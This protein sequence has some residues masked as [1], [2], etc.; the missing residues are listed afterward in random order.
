MARAARP[1]GLDIE[2]YNAKRDFK[3]TKEPKGRR[4]K[5]KGDSFVVQKH[6]ASRL[7]WD[8]RLELD[9]VLKSWAVPKGPSLDPK[10]NR[11]AMRTED[12]PLDYG[13]FEGIIP[14]GEYGGGTVMLWDR[15]RW[16]PHPDKDPRKTL[17]EGHLHFTLEG[18]RMKGEWVMFRMKGK[19]GE[20]GEAWVLKKVT[21]EAAAPDEGD[22]LVD[23]CLT[24][25]ETGRSMAEIA[26]GEDV[27][28]SNRGGKKGGRTKRKVTPPP[29]F[30]E[31]QLATLADTPPTG[32]GWLHEYKYDGY[33]LLLSVGEG[34]TVAWTRGGKDWSNFF[35]E[36]TEAATASLPAG[37]LID[38][39]AV[40][41]DEA[42]KPNFGL[43]QSTVKG[44]KG[45]ERPNRAFY[46]FDLLID[47]GEDIR[48]LSNLE[49]KE[50]LASLMKG[51]PGPLV[52]GDHVIGKGEQLLKTICADGGEGIIS[53]KADAAYRGVRTKCWLKVKCI[54]RQ[55]F[56]IVGWQASDKRR[57]FRS[58]H[59]GVNEG[60]AL[61]YVGKVGTGFDTATLESLSE[62]M[63]PLKL[64]KPALEVP[65]TALRGSTW[66]TPELVAEIAYTEFTSDGV[67]RHPSFLGLREDKTAKQVV[68][69]TPVAAPKTRSAAKLR[70]AA[71]FKLRL[72]SPEKV[73]FP[74]DGLTK[75]DLA[76]YYAAVADL[77]MV[78]L[79]KRPMTLIRCPSGRA[80]KCFFQKH[81]SGSMGEH[82]L[83]IPV[84]E[85]AGTTEEDYLFVEEPLGMLECVQ[86]NTIEF[87][88][89]G[90][91]ID[92]LEKPDRLVFDLDPDEGLG[93]DKVK[94]AAVRLRD[95]LA[96]LGLETFPLLSGG[97]G[98]HVIAPLDQEAEW[99][100]VK[101]FA[102]RFSRA[103]ADAEPE[104]F[105]ANIRKNQRKGR[106][107]LDWLRNQRGATAVMPY[108]ARAREGAPVA[109]PVSWEE[110]EGVEKASL[111]TIRDAAQLLERAGG[112]GLKGWGQSKQTL[113][114]V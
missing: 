36:L 97:K 96:D 35:P 25:V 114:S 9:G 70:T 99:P 58:L 102:E 66:I 43:L 46:A 110:L 18:E 3:K 47:R 85:G 54:A 41:L 67:L 72:T 23:G 98:I 7:H 24:S 55:E 100:A 84:K 65:R 83:R 87:H 60:G 64:A 77:L 92:P 71:D 4:R 108:S 32:S 89:W 76:D 106:I 62:R 95:L 2:T 78:D 81:D 15:G 56:V 91:R 109:A 113:P 69:E 53:K 31:P 51:V 45:Q 39:E 57:G 12:H 20:K 75:G 80:K 8:F 59:L 42:G 48:K 107:F 79:A 14:A 82:V 16:I 11:L 28:V 19:P 49:R 13:T 105:T 88:G 17:E 63:A 111:Y 52:Y 61:R 73:I 30:Q 40:A 86:M 29:P 68:L 50:R 90:S 26:A 33:R 74:E 6:D 27:W 94:A 44:G 5:G 93:F 37:C 104:T 34:G 10:V 101:S 1:K 21:D 112:K 22:A 103:I 38:G